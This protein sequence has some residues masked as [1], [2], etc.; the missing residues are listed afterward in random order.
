MGARMSRKINKEDTWIL[1][2]FFAV[3]GLYVMI[4]AKN[5]QDVKEGFFLLGIGIVYMSA[6]SDDFREK[7]FDFFL[8][9]FR[10]LWNILKK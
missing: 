1:G 4:T 6:V 9:I 8:S 10:G 7:V 3:I 2:G 5:I